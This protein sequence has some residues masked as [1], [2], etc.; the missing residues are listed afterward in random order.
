[1]NIQFVDREMEFGILNA[2]LMKQRGIF[3]LWGRRRV[4]K[5]RLLTE[6][7][8]EKESVYLLATKETEKAILRN[9]SEELGRHYNDPALQ[10]ASFD[11]FRDML[12]YLD[13]R[14]QNKPFL[15]ILDE[16]PYLCDANKSIPS[17]L[18]A[19]WD[20]HHLG[21]MHI[22]LSGSTVSSMESEVLAVKS[23]L[24]G[25]RAGQYKLQPLGP[26]EAKGFFPLMGWEDYFRLYTVV[27]GTP[28]Y[29]LRM[30]P[31]KTLRDNIV[32]N[33]AA[34]GS[35]LLDEPEL[36]L[37]TEVREPRT[38][39]S[40]MKALSH[41][42]A[43][44]NEI[45]TWVGIPRTSVLGY[46]EMLEKLDLVHRRL[47][48]TESDNS[49][50]GRYR[51]KDNFFR[52]YF[53]FI[54][55]NLQQ[56]R[57]GLNTG[58]VDSLDRD[59]NSFMGQSFETVVE[60]TLIAMARADQFRFTQ[61]GPWWDGKDEIDLVALNGHEVTFVECKWSDLDAREGARILSD[62]KEKAKKVKF[63]GPGRKERFII[64]AKSAEP[65]PGARILTVADIAGFAER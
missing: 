2:F 50:R 8:K 54:F 12:R 1:M 32:K 48:I 63:G 64:A 19:E 21:D 58:L 16:F 5:S 23:P 20:Q 25:R 17:V 3:V 56:I 13:K 60:S 47:P 7:A 31:K 11:S 65:V 52:F 61:L 39:F 46:M 45:A 27:G 38:Y 51:I 35:M 37:K 59:F 14:R 29:L 33:I 44:P 36:L 62:L 57:Q 41:G 4:G 28:E 26:I 24:Y 34:P 30:D 42:R 22:I 53:R 49:R 9:F 6:F 10:G 43:T 40:L 15:L 18:Q 55:P